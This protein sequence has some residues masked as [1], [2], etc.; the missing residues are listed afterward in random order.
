MIIKFSVM[1]KNYGICIKLAYLAGCVL[2]C[3]NSCIKDE[4]SPVEIKSGASYQGGIIFYIDGSGEHGLIAATS[5]QSAT[6]PWW[7]GSYVIT[8]ASSTSNGS[9]NTTAIVPVTVQTYIVVP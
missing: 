8:G 7:N 5:D 3:F 1:N 4:K 2:I 6:D 9:S